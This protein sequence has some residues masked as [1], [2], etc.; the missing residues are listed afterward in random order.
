MSR[1]PPRSQQGRVVTWWELA[2]G[3]RRSSLKAVDP[4][5]ES[6]PK[7][8]EACVVGKAHPEASHSIEL[9]PTL[10]PGMSLCGLPAS[11][12]AEKLRQT[13]IRV[14]VP[15][16]IQ[17]QPQPPTGAL[18]CISLNTCV[19]VDRIFRPLC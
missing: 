14:P 6:L 11:T 8:L 3:S 2:D 7:G 19:G 9:R 16:V 18:A 15:P 1:P 12:T 17:K 13:G 4:A 10:K 5:E